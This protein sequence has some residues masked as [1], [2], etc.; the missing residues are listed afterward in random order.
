MLFR[1]SRYLRAAGKWRDR[2]GVAQ[3]RKSQHA[4]GCHRTEQKGEL[5]S[6]PRLFSAAQAGM[7]VQ[8][9]VPGSHIKTRINL[10]A[11]IKLLAYSRTPVAERSGVV[12]SW[13]VV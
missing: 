13:R 4:R 12:S 5:L 2:L 1:S 9:A 7:G 8:H 10:G 3:G 11:M 6:E